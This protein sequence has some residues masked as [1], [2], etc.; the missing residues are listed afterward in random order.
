M[1]FDITDIRDCETVDDIRNMADISLD[2]F[3]NLIRYAKRLHSEASL[4]MRQFAKADDNGTL[5]TP[6]LEQARIFFS[7]QFNATKNFFHLCEKAKLL[8]TKTRR[9]SK[10]NMLELVYNL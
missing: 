7:C 6:E 4:A 8:P 5:M 2:A 10:K 3:Q 1:K 9:M